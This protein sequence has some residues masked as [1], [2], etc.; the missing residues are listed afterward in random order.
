LLQTTD[1]PSA[2]QRAK[3]AI[4][5]TGLLSIWQWMLKS[6]HCSLVSN[7][8]IRKSVLRQIH[9]DLGI[10]SAAASATAMNADARVSACY[11]WQ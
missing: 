9:C 5:V 1:A 4:A 11:K 3:T 6:R 7:L 10:S 2:Y 8:L